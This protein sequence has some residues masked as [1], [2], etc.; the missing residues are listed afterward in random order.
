MV[1]EVITR[2]EKRRVLEAWWRNFKKCREMKNGEWCV[3]KWREVM[4]SEVEWSEVKWSEIVIW[5][6]MY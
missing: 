5:D 2:E 1:K 6:G 3:V 4:C